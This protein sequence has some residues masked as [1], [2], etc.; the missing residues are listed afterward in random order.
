MPFNKP[1]LAE[2]IGTAQNDLAG[3]DGLRHSDGQVLS[4]VH[5]GGLYGLYGYLGWVADQILPDTCDEDMLL[6]HADLR[7]IPGRLPAVAA[8]GPASFIGAAGAGVDVGTLL[9]RKDGVRFRVVSPVVLQGAT[10]AVQLA[11]VDP[12]I[13]GNTPAGTELTLV[14][15]VLGVQG[16]FTVTG[17]GLQG[18]VAEETIEALRARV[19]RSY[20]ALPHGGN[21][22]D[23]QTW[24]LEVPG[25]TRVWVRRHWVGPG[26]VGVFVMRDGDPSPFPDEAALAVIKAYIEAQRPITA[27]L[28]VLAP[29]PVAVQY[30][31][32]VTP[33]TPAV[34]AAVEAELKALHLRDGALGTTLLRTHISEAISGAAGERDHE[35]VEPVANVTPAG[36]QLL[37]YGGVQWL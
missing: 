36:N 13:L 18:G 8:S 9:Q 17:N 2:L 1:T 35:I 11:A 3:A 10:G 7:P 27:E 12:G 31:L 25:V 21:T 14:S 19:L 26:T 32:R 4:R 29:A 24:A 33:D 30:R 22:D 15:P 23:Y 6:R 28:H 37:V 20:R 5:A 16:V 34:R